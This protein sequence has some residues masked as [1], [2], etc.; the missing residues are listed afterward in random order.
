MANTDKNILITPNRGSSTDDPNIVF[1]GADATTA[2]QNISLRVYPTNNGTLSFEGSAGQLFSITNNLSGTIFSVNDVSGIPS[3][4]VEDDGTVKLAEFAGNVL[5]GSGVDNGVDKLQITGTTSI[6]GNGYITFGPNSSW[7]SSLRVGGNG[8]TATG[9]EMASVVTTDGNLHLDAAASSNAIYLN[10]YA[11]TGGTFF[12]NGAGTTVAVMGPD[13]DLWKGSSDNSGSKYWHAGNDGSGSG[14]DADL[15][16]GVGFR[17]TNSGGPINAN[18]LDSNGITY[19]TN[20]DGS[21]ANLSGNATDGALYSQ[22]YSSTWQHQIYGDYRSGQIFVRG[23]NNGTWQAWNRVW[24]AGNDG[25]GSG[26]DADTVDGIQAASFLRSDASDTVSPGRQISF[27]SYDAGETSTG[28]QASLE[29]YQDTAGADAF[30]QFHVGGDYACYFGLAGDW[31]DLFVGGWSMGNNV[32]HRIW[33][34]GNDGSGSGLD[35]DLLDGLQANDIAVGMAQAAGWIPT[36]SNSDENTVRWNFTEDAVELQSGS[37]TAIGA[38]YKAFRV[39]ENKEY[40]ITVFVRASAAVSSGLYIRMYEYDAELPA[41]K[42]WVSNDAQ[43]PLVQE[44]TRHN[45]GP[46]ENAAIGTSWTRY[47][48]TYTPSASA[49]WASIVILNWDGIG[50]NS[51]YLLEPDIQP[52]KVHDSDTLDGLNST[53]FMRTDTTTTTAGGIIIQNSSPTLY[54]QDTDHRSSMVHCNSNIWY[55]LRGSGTN[56]T[57]WTQTGAGWPIQINL[58]N[59]DITFGGVITELSDARLKQNV[60]SIGNSLEILKAIEPRRYEWK[61]DGHAD[62]G[63]IA[64]EV[65][66]GGFPEVVRD[67][68]NR[69]PETGV[70]DKDLPIRKTLDYG[71]MV[72]VVWDVARQQQDEIE[73]LKAEIEELKALIKAKL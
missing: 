16:D 17:N 63:F 28:D 2:P 31:N 36:Y 69:D 9:S 47:T 60:T 53:Q 57:S 10:Y 66:A 44:D 23:K 43:H 58:E 1:S 56:S 38:A 22:A 34:A 13:G 72:A 3:I 50:T 37:D 29:V 46:A 5:F 8:R 33:H 15:I 64:Q 41:G 70:L 35:A 65:E 25:S 24:T 51:L 11:G 48:F 52:L 61:H 40:V 54:L 7:G 45:G 71:R 14:L 4:E 55:V 39:R 26:L 67:S 32:R 73:K 27:Y 12:G 42:R 59:N 49:Y 18:T 21:S 68:E 6:A 19:V 30:M 62:I 20:V